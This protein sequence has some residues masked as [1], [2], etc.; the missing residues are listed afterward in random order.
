MARTHGRARKRKS[1]GGRLI[2]AAR[3][4]VP[5]W[6]VEGET[7]NSKFQTHSKDAIYDSHDEMKMSCAIL[8]FCA[9]PLFAQAT[10]T[11]PPALEKAFSVLMAVTS[12]RR[13]HAR[14]R[15]PERMGCRRLWR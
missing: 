6:F 15:Q 1:V 3:A 7:L 8:A 11:A 10:A 4:V 5:P 2:P 14:G 13:I 9:V 12:K